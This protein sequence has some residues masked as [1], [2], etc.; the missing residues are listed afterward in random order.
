MGGFVLCGLV[1]FGGQQKL[2]VVDSGGGNF[3]FTL[4]FVY[5]LHLLFS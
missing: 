5:L 1:L 2:I 3:N 4:V